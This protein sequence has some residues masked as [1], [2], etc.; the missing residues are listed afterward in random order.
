MVEGLQRSDELAVCGRPFVCSALPRFFASFLF[1]L[2]FSAVLCLLFRSFLD[3][4]LSLSIRF[5]SGSCPLQMVGPRHC[6]TESERSIDFP[7]RLRPPYWLSGS[8]PSIAVWRL[9]GTVP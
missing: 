8:D 1:S 9:A 4:P 6:P 5:S 3:R 7:F 2:S